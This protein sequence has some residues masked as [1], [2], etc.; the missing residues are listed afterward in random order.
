MAKKITVECKIAVC[1]YCK[2]PIEL[3]IN[4]VRSNYCPMCGGS[5]KGKKM[6][7]KM[8]EKTVSIFKSN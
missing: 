3:Y 1:P 6:K 7:I 4:G 2:D 8:I 5:L